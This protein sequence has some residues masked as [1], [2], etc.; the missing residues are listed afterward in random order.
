MTH[1]ITRQLVAPL[2]Y[3]L[4]SM[5]CGQALALE[6]T[7]DFL[8][9]YSIGLSK[10]TLRLND[11]D[12]RLSPETVVR[13]MDQAD[14]QSDPLL[15]AGKQYWFY[16]PLINRSTTAQWAIRSDHTL[17]SELDFYLHCR[18]QS[19]QA[20][21]RPTLGLD[22]PTLASAYFIP[23]NL[24][25]NTRCGF[26]Q[27]GRTSM[28]DGVRI[29]LVPHAK[30]VWE[31]NLKTTLALLGM[32]AVIGLILYNLLLYL[33]LRD[34]MY[35]I[36]IG[37][38]LMHLISAIVF[39]FNPEPLGNL[40]GNARQ[41]L[42]GIG[43]LTAI[44]FILFA[45][46]FMQ[47]GISSLHQSSTKKPLFIL[48]KAIISLNWLAIVFMLGILLTASFYP[49]S[50]AK[51]AGIYPFIYLGCIL[52]IP[53]LSLV[54]ALSGY[55]PAWIFLAA[56]TALIIG[57]ILFILDGQVIMNLHGLGMTYGLLAAALEMVLL[58]IALGIAIKDTQAARDS[59]QLASES[60][61]LRMEQ[62]EKFIS[63]L[64]HEIRTPL[65]AMLGSTTLLGRTAL[66][67]KQKDYWSTTHYAA[68]SMYALVDNLLDRT[69]A[70]Q[71]E[72]TDNNTTFNPQLLLEAMISLLRNRAEEKQLTLHLHTRELP[73][74]LLGKPIVLRRMLINLISNA[75]KYT[76]SGMIEVSARWLANRHEL[77]ITVEDTGRGM[78]PEQLTQIKARFNFGVE[79]LYSQDASSGLG[80]PICFEM[81]K[82][83]GGHLSLDSQL[84]QGTQAHFYLKMNLPTTTDPE[85]ATPNR[86]NSKPLKVLVVDD[87]PSNRM[88]TYELLAAVGHTVT[89]AKDARQ[90]LKLLQ[91][92][93]FNTVIS[94]VRMPG[95]N[96]FALLAALRQR[97]NPSELRV[98]MTSAHFD[99]QQRDHLLSMGADAC[100]AKPYTPTE[101]LASLQK[102]V[103]DN[104]SNTLEDNTFSHLKERLGDEKV[105]QVLGLYQ[106]QLQEDIA[107]IQ[108]AAEEQDINKLRVAAH[109]IVSA[110]HAL[111]LHRNADAAL[112]LETFQEHAPMPDWSSFQVLITRQLAVLTVQ[113]QKL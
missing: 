11:P 91:K 68:E 106:A 17:Y 53:L 86:E 5:V 75:I 105:A 25:P 89:Q 72:I 97:Y 58:S 39:H 66:S 95:M 79:S 71:A 13:R 52:L 94:D 22:S 27:R 28:F 54:V 46:R 77:H 2:L 43:A 99:T 26:L 67:D 48:V 112:Q 69:Q 65:H 41:T 15:A 50:Q 34:S 110:S 80:L 76:D 14:F 49:A 36:Y 7:D 42:W 104:Q 57:H 83:A 37:Y 103:P 16:I 40:L 113:H 47:P 1:P 38:A 93:T 74:Y 81:I 82:A 85:L 63:T 55:K 33:P 111:G 100:L 73:K 29:S 107:R 9:A 70:K 32:G 44:F 18:G 10:E 62:Q 51:V 24:P 12:N 61:E 84:E 31:S 108:Q 98:V 6:V 20:I 45:L 102:T 60:A 88:I 109:R 4:L 19:L 87:I 64:S 90:A 35:L 21:P 3:L 8:Q 78:S 96:G 56:W 30:M 92:Q 59:A 101:L 23:I